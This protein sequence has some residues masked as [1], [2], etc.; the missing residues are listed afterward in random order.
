M[1][2]KTIAIIGATGGI[3]R[4]F[5]NSLRGQNTVYE[6]SRSC[7]LDYAEETSIARAAQSVC[8]LD[9]ILIATGFLH[10]EEV[11]PEKSIRDLAAHKFEKN[12]LINCVGPALVMKYFLPKLKRNKQTAC[13]VLSA[14]VGS[15][16]DNVLGGWTAYRASKAALNMVIKNMAIETARRN[17]KAVIIGL[18]PGTVDTDLSAPFQANIRQDRLFT[19]AYS[20]EK[21]LEVINSITPVDSGKVFAW[22]GKE[23]PA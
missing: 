20:A 6:F 12:F 13:A 5:A 10:D 7:G 1:K 2:N 21:L 23:V 17:K 15:I 22:D 14:R 19:P 3:G 4:A 16:S 9:M 8:D 11:V 18:H